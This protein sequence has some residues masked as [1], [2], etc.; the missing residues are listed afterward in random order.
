MLSAEELGA[1]L[2]ETGIEMQEKDVLAT[3]R[4]FDTDNS[5]VV[6]IDEVPWV[7]RGLSKSAAAHG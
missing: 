5:G 7:R 4:A 2:Q 6:E 1:A 3:I